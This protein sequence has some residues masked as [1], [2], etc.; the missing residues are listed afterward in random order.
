MDQLSH[1]QYTMPIYQLASYCRCK[2]LWVGR[3]QAD[4][5]LLCLE[6]EICLMVFKSN[7]QS[8][9]PLGGL[10][11]SSW[12]DG[13]NIAQSVTSLSLLAPNPYHE[14]SRICYLMYTEPWSV[15]RTDEF[16]RSDAI[17]DQEIWCMQDAK[18]QRV[19]P[20][21]SLSLLLSS[22]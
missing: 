14:A 11:L 15:Q 22:P 9:A 3:H 17:V 12:F 7:R 16:E 1:T 10:P 6:I 13:K 18:W 4:C 20:V 19:V 21:L 5:W 8:S 2:D